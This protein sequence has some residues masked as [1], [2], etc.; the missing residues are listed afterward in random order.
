[1]A[2][3]HQIADLQKVGELLAIRWSDGREDYLPLTELRRA[4]PCASCA[5]E[6]DL[7]GKNVMPEPDRAKFSSAL[8]GW[9]FV[10]CYG[11]QPRWADGHQTGIY[12]LASLRQ[13]GE[14]LA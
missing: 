12:T 7:T 2:E 8:V 5:G 14:K 9:G 4:C 11:I 10:G 6:Y 13:L 3:M 1:M